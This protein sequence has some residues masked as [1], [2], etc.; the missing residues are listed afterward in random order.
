TQRDT[1]LGTYLRGELA[2]VLGHD[3]ASTPINPQQG[4]FALGMDSLMAVELRTRLETDLEIQ[5]PSTIAFDRATLADLQTDIAA[6]LFPALARTP[7]HAPSHPPAHFAAPAPTEPIAIIGLGCRFPG[8]VST[9]AEFWSLLRDG[10]HGAK[11][12]PSERWSAAAHYH[13][14]PEQAGKI[15]ARAAGFIDGVDLFDHAFFN[16]YPREA[17]SMDPQQRLLLETAWQALESAG[18]A[19]AQLRGSATGTFVG[20]STND[21][22]QLL[23]KSGDATRIDA[24]FGTGNALN[25]V[26]GRLAYTFGLRGPALV[27][28]TACSSSLVALHQA[29]Q[30][31][32]AGECS[33]ALAAGVNLMLTPEPAIALSRA[34]MLSPDGRC[35]TF[36]ASAD[37]Y[38]RGEGCGV[39]VL[40]RLSDARAAGDPVLA[41]ITGSAI[42]QD[43][44]SSGFTVPSGTAQQELIHRALA[45]AGRTPDELDYVEVHGT[46]TPLGDPIE[47]N[48]LSEVVGRSRARPLIVA[49]VKTNL[50]HLESAA[51]IAGIIK[52]VLSLQHDAIP[53]HL[54]FT[55]PSPHIPWHDL[56]VT[57][58]TALTAWPASPG[59]PRV[60]GV[61]AFG[62]TGTNA[63]VILE[64]A[65]AS[66]PAP[67]AGTPQ[68]I[69]IS[70]R[71]P[72]AL[73]AR[74][75]SILAWLDAR[76]DLALADIA[77]TLGTGRT[78]FPLR[79]AYCAAT[80]ADL[81]A[82]LR[83]RLATPVP[84]TASAPAPLAFVCTT[85]GSRDLGR[86]WLRWGL[87]PALVLGE[88]AG[89]VAAGALAGIFSDEDATRLITDPA[90]L[91]SLTLN[92]P[93][94]GFGHHRLGR[95]PD[96]T[97]ASPA[98]WRAAFAGTT[99]APGEAFPP[100]RELLLT[101]LADPAA[102]LRLAADLYAAAYDLDWSALNSTPH[103]RHL[104]DAPTYPFQRRRHWIDTTPA[105]SASVSNPAPI[106]RT[107]TDA[108]TLLGDRIVLPGTREIRF[109]TTYSD[110][111]GFIAHPRL[112][113]RTIASGAQHL[114][115]IIAA[116]RLALKT[117]TLTATAIT[118]SRALML[119]EG[120]TRDVQLVLSPSDDGGTA[121]RVLSAPPQAGDEWLQHAH[122]TLRPGLAEETP[123][124]T[125]ELSSA[126][127]E[128]PG[129]EFH[130]LL[131]GIGYT[132]GPSFCWVQSV[133]TGNHTSVALLAPPPGTLEPYG[134]DLHPGLIDS[135]FQLIGWSAGIDLEELRDGNAIYIPT[136]IDTVR[137]HRRPSQRPL[138]CHVRLADSAQRR[139]LLIRGDLR[140]TEEDGTLIFEVLG[141]EARR[142]ARSIILTDQAAPA[143]DRFY[144]ITWAE[145]PPTPPPAPTASSTWT[146]LGESPLATTLGERLRARGDLLTTSITKADHVVLLLDAAADQNSADESSA[147][148][149]LT[150]VQSLA[151]RSPSP[152][153]WVVTRGA[154]AI[155]GDALPQS[156]SAAAA[157]GLGRI[158]ALEH[159]ALQLRLLD[160]DP[161][162]PAGEDAALE[163]ALFATDD[164]N[165]IA[166]RG[167]RRLAAR[168]TPTAPIPH[169]G[170]SPRRLAIGQYG[171]LDT[172]ALTPKP[173]LPL[174]PGEVE[175]EVRAVGLNFRDVLSALGLL[176]DHLA[177]LGVHSES[178]L[179]F[180]GECAGVIRAV[181]AAVT[182]FRPG[183]AVLTGLATG[184]MGSHIAVDA[185][186]IVAKP[187]HLSFAEAATLPVAYLTAYYALHT[188]A[189]VQPGERVL[190]HAAA[191][192]V[193]VAAIHVAHLLGAEVLATASP[194]KWPALRALG[195]SIIGHSRQTDYA[196][197]FP[198]ADVVLNALV[199]D[200]IPVS[201]DLLNPD[202][203]FVEIGKLG[204]W[205]P[206]QV[207]ARRP[208]VAYLPFDLVQMD[209]TSPLIIGDLLREIAPHWN[210]RRL[211]PLPLRIYSL[212]DA[213]AAF[214]F[215]AQA[216]HTG[217]VV[218]VHP[219]AVAPQPR[220]DGAYL[221][222]G[223]LGGL[224]LAVAGWLARAGA[225]TIILTSRRAPDTAQEA[226]LAAFRATGARVLWRAADLSAPGAVTALIAA[227]IAEHGSL[228]GIFHAAGI[229]DDG[230]IRQQTPARLAGVFAPKA[231]AAWELHTATLAQPLD[232]FV[233]FSSLAAVLGSPGQATYAAANAALDALAQHRRRLGRPALSI[234]WGPWAE[235]G[236]SARL[237]ERERARFTALGLKPFTNAAGITA[238]TDLLAGLA[239]QVA[240]VDLDRRALLAS[241]GGGRT[242]PLLRHLASGHSASATAG[243]LAT[244]LGLTP[245]AERAAFI[246]HA[247]NTRLATALGLAAGENLPT[248][249]NLTSLGFDS[250]TAV[251]LQSWIGGEFNVEIPMRQIAGFTLDGLAR[252]ILA[253]LQLEADASSADPEAPIENTL[254][255]DAQLPDDVR[256]AG[257]APVLA[258]PRNALLT[259]ATGFLGAFL[260]HE[261]LNTTAA[262][263]HC[264]VRARSPDEGRERILENLRGYGL[265]TAHVADRLVIVPGDL[266][267]PH[268]G[269]DEA[270]FDQL[271]R[272]VDTIYHN[273]AWLNFFYPY[274]ALRA[275]NVLGTLEVLRL[276]VR[277]TAKPVH[278]VS[279]SGV[280]YSRAYRGQALLET[281]PAEHCDGH[282]LGYSQT[283]WVAERL[284]T[285]AAERGLPVT[286]HRAPFIT[287]HR[288]TGAWNSDDFICRLVRGIIA[289]RAM[290]DLSA[291]MDIVPVDYV[292]RG[293]IRLSQR[294]EAAGQRFH[295]CAPREVP[296]SA[297]S[298][299]LAAAGYP[300]LREP[301][302]AWLG[303][304]PALRGTEHPLAPFVA[305][306]LE[307]AG[308]DRP[309]VPEV[310]LQSAH[311]RLDGDATA[312]TLT[313]YGLD[314][315]VIDAALW[316]GY[317][318][319]LRSDGSLPDPT[320]P[321][322]P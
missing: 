45:L 151:G 153:L 287:G 70:A 136:S 35:K 216:K 93:R 281:N 186:L 85:A 112:F 24:Y 114:A 72:E 8:G 131:S 33:Q 11:P 148:R 236:M 264:V 83:A 202:G 307:K 182:H 26:A 176:K 310:F 40:K 249:R 204:I 167:P 292:A 30:S 299:W 5:L 46:G 222:T 69:P 77:R 129:P 230:L 119:N 4:F 73:L 308:P 319:K 154:Q 125:A 109:A 241:L 27:T 62:F 159:P 29:C 306:F 201:L 175:I 242:P 66:P 289:L 179:P 279:T 162:A 57:V 19:N 51:G 138:R 50:G 156:L 169:P 312:C 314:A 76:P 301:Y 214:R 86:Q 64:S 183:D 139:A 226:T 295:L 253:G 309:T 297:L 147:A 246:I 193:G 197:E 53:A 102:T 261:L 48:A 44:A 316:R 31:L 177:S 123:A 229:I 117:D 122:A 199:G 1:V 36:D 149:L 75:S 47:I 184:C 63:H 158:A 91:S 133:C 107:R 140:L 84:S 240:A 274:A 41:V 282:A 268:L 265:P 208:D 220:G 234:N 311:A 174:A 257:P 92:L 170:D 187:P 173:R 218:L 275:A 315:P 134:Y 142:A 106:A 39:V 238:F 23:L 71:T 203:R 61:S 258:A 101:P 272:S 49:S 283:K 137:F 213:P 144:E 9:P 164:E 210:A 2:R 219:P 21:Y 34:R 155:P 294:P 20:V 120:E 290:P 78:H 212:T 247:I 256:P 293:I 17:A 118:Y 206:E 270:A 99:V 244:Q 262:V 150:L 96:A 116:A 16:L 269:L 318:E 235:A 188:L 80:T 94:I 32:R 135:C 291:S 108:A 231:R 56:P 251:E 166:L 313:A 305:L 25:A 277:G 79:E 322:P 168:L 209:R 3:A 263:I 286:I 10:R 172:L 98:W 103:A 192:G 198:K 321:P 68:L 100:H 225:G 145:T 88:D 276:A 215:M 22:A 146:L 243:Q 207:A 37:G 280:F 13:A 300:V 284:V 245:A 55:R 259:G 227:C 252:A 130:R 196:R 15:I 317:L 81:R 296:W 221:V 121:A 60:A 89:L 271:A 90:A 320:P 82:Q 65:S 266:A 185:R 267:S 7:A 110:A 157:I 160:L 285:A 54:G 124:W 233:L 161:S 273:G 97:A 42:N 87:A 250:L 67:P 113:G 239:P 181:G 6:R 18:L 143:S 191:G 178:D 248:D 28:D 104:P 237:G 132:L 195:V 190:I 127:A 165:Q 14:D 141:F 180:G 254:H 43:G 298:D 255:A 58:P 12:V 115:V 152:R 228:R 302:A 304:L 232:F 200:H 52:T 223:G 260:L 38:G 278:Y 126:A 171:N 194:S 74:R 288:E 105:V 163:H 189:R 128:T 111:Q 95:I 217:K 303:R 224:G 59:R 205:T 211:P